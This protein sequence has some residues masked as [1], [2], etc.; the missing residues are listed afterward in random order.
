MEAPRSATIP[1][2]VRGRLRVF[3]DFLRE[4][5]GIKEI[6][7]CFQGFASEPEDIEAGLLAVQLLI[8]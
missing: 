4:N 5:A 1:Q 2:N 6:V 8:H 7:G 3:D